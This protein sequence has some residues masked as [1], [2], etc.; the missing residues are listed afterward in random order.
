MR[1]TAVESTTLA[2]V[3][4]DRTQKLLQLEFRSGAIYQY[5]DVPVA[6]HQALL[7][8][9]SKGSYFN[10][11]VRRCY[12]CSRVGR[13]LAAASVPVASGCQRQQEAV[14]HVR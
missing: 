6:V 8:A 10:Q 3:G 14:W 9:S 5:F 11:T 13:I 7:R 12:A 1:F 2:K 4:Y